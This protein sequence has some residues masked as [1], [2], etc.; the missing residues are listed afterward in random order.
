MAR[1]FKSRAVSVPLCFAII[2]AINASA[3]SG[4]PITPVGFEPELSGSQLVVY[5]SHPVWVRG[6]GANTF[7][8]RYERFSPGNADP[9][10]RFSAPLRHRSLIDLQFARGTAP[11]MLFGPRVTWDM[12]R[13][14]LGPTDGMKPVWPLFK[15][16]S[17]AA[18]APMVP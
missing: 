4:N 5:V 12:G 7:G 15:P 6:S 10:A 14:Q 3:W 17:S 11:Q 16:P 1:L 2:V 18:L 8:F 13:R 9:S